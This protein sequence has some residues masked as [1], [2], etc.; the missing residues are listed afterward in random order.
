MPNPLSLKYNLLL[1]FCP[2]AV[3]VALAPQ[4]DLIVFELNTVRSADASI[5][6]ICL[7]YNPL[8]YDLPLA[9]P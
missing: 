5:L 7:L 4:A 3:K 1:A 6:L 2:N 8:F 9:A